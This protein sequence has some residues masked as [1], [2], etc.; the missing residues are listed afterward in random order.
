MSVPLPILDPI[1]MNEPTFERCQLLIDFLDMFH[2]AQEF[3]AWAFVVRGP[4]WL[5]Q[6]RKMWNM[7]Q[8]REAGMFCA[9]VYFRIEDP[10]FSLLFIQLAL[11]LLLLFDPRRQP[12]NA[13]LHRLAEGT[14]E[15][16]LC[17]GR[18]HGRCKLR[19]RLFDVLAQN[20]LQLVTRVADGTM[21]PLLEPAFLL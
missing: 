10:E 12:P 5:W 19:I 4:V 21:N 6:V 3:P 20:L 7:R 17:I 9:R 18:L 16:D 13:R 15:P 14:L 11:S 2:R 8:V 1:F